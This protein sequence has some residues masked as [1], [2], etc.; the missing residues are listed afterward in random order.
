MLLPV[1]GPH[2]LKLKNE[3]H[4]SVNPLVQ[5]MLLLDGKAPVREGAKS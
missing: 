4:F 5:K 1:D 2:W 3:P